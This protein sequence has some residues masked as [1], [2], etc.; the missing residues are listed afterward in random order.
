MAEFKEREKAIALRKEKQM[1]YGQIK[2]ILKVSKS[3]L[4]YWL[5]NYPLSEKRIKELQRKGWEKSE[6]SRE[7]FRIT[8]RKK[9]EERLKK[10]YKEQR[11]IIFPFNKREFFLAGLFLYWG[12]GSKTHP[13]ELSISNTNP[14]I[15]KFFISWLTNSLNVPKEKLRVQLHLYRDMNIRKEIQFWSKI[16][17]LPL[18]QFNKP[19]IKK[20]STNRINH[21]GGFGH[22]TCN[23]TIGNTRLAERIHMSIKAIADKYYKKGT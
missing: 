19:Y 23:V 14:S 8:M 1:S 2:K 22:G 13:G 6:T 17:N 9:K 21:K 16:L 15:I 5:R 10:F 3:T 11:K 4:S 7:R 18:S 12:E 20:S